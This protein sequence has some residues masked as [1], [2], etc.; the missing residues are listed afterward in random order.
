MKKIKKGDRIVFKAATRWGFK[1]ATRIVNGFWDNEPT[2]R[3]GG[4]SDFV[5]HAHE[6]KEVI[7]N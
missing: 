4:W 2:V 7:K 5:V 6:I 1:K 3:F